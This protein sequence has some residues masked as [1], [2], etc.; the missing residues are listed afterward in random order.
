MRLPRFLS[1]LAPNPVFLAGYLAWAAVAIGLWRIPPVF[2]P[3]GETVGRIGSVLCMLAFVFGI[4]RRGSDGG[5]IRSLSLMV[6]SAL[7][8]LALGAS[9]F[10]PVLLI[11][12]AAA[13][14]AVYSTRIAVAA[15]VALNLAFL[16]ILLARWRVADPA[17]TLLVYGSFETFALLTTLERVRAERAS[18]E[19]RDVNAQLLATRELLA[20]SAR[21][22]E[23]LR[24]SRELH[25]VAGHR[26]TALVLNLDLLGQ[27]VQV[28]E[29]REWVVSRELVTRLLSDLRSVVANLRRHDGI[30]VR[31]ALRR[32]AEAF[33]APQI[34]LSLDERV[35]IEGAERATAIVRAGQE[36]LTNAVRHANARNIWL[37]L[38]RETDT[39]RLEVR[40]DGHCRG[41]HVAGRGLRGM[42]ERVDLL[43]GRVET[44][45]SP[46]GGFR[47]RVSLPMGPEP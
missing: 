47:L 8:L 41:V 11:I 44:D 26:L 3:L 17:F 16:G 5:S 9:G 25:D 39:L 24:V 45:A 7:V 10:T 34:H 4:V 31:E 15:L 18:R 14:G 6:I 46:E 29:R 13:L 37:S 35:R 36:G 20:E 43:G 32:I 33:P 28:S 30:D 19:L 1:G 12:I 38:G 27:D 42:Q 23:R 21:D 40:D 22:G 2:A